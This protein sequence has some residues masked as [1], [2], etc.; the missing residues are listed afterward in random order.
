M[1]ALWTEH[2]S[3]HTQNSSSTGFLSKS[4]QKPWEEHKP[5]KHKVILLHYTLSASSFFASL[6]YH[7][8]FS[9]FVDISPWLLLLP[10]SLRGKLSAGLPNLVTVSSFK[11]QH[12]HA[13]KSG[14]MSLVLVRLGLI[15]HLLNVC[16]TMPRH[17]GL[18]FPKD[19]DPFSIRFPVTTQYIIL[20][21]G[22][23]LKMQTCCC[24]SFKNMQDA[25]IH[26]VI[27]SLQ[28]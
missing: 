3:G 14:L 26:P 2:Q 28:T 12:K 25:L 19:N 8:R 10:R 20:T 4:S 22:R 27:S 23:A 11:A 21:L 18:F 5:Q 7:A 6:K 17:S 15:K 1:Q 9:V 16:R 24:N 13:S